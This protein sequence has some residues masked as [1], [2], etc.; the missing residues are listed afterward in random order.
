M[1]TEHTPGP[2]FIWKE[3]AM[4]REGLDAD[5][6]E[7]E[8]LDYTGHEICAG[9]PSE[10]TRGRLRGHTAGICTLDADNY[11]FDDDEDACKSTALANARL[12][13]AAPELL[14]A[15]KMVAKTLDEH[16]QGLMGNQFTYEYKEWSL[17]VRAAIAKAEG[18]A[19]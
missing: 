3:L 17:A 14:K 9:T 2:W 12:I 6:I 19:A 11:D 7:C 13:A 16:E 18:G 4:Q 5:E 10:C 1:S 8:L 15:L